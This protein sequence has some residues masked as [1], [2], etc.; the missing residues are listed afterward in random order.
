M[1]KRGNEGL[2]RHLAI[3]SMTG[4]S[5][6]QAGPGADA[7]RSGPLR[8]V[9]K[10]QHCRRAGSPPFARNTLSARKTTA[11]G[12][13][14]GSRVKAGHAAFS[15]SAGDPNGLM[16]CGYPLTVAG[17]AGVLHPVPVFIPVSGEPSTLPG[18]ISR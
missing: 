1:G 10:V 4:Q 6:R 5:A 14:P 3:P 7:R 9:R 11:K 13:S 18:A 16:A 12:R 15:G 2:Q 8:A 17:A